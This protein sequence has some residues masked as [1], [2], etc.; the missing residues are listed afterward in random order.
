MS[1]RRSQAGPRDAASLG[2]GG[3]WRNAP[4]RW[5]HTAVGLHWLS[6]LMIFAL[7]VLGWVAVSWRLSP[8]KIE[9][10]VWHKSLGLTVLALTA[11]RVAWRLLDPRPAFP[12]SMRAWERRLA[13]VSHLALYL[14]LLLM[15][16]SGWIINSAANFPLKWFWVLPVPSLVGPSKGVQH[17]AEA[18]HL[19]LFW[20]LAVALSLH[21]AAALKHHFRD[22]DGVLT[23]MLPGLARRG[24][25]RS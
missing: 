2:S 5:G 12:A 10:F 22:R 19:A 14:I 6:A 17:G 8:T 3:R 16:L 25:A 7:M 15:P 13:G 21:V 4:T 18:V 9:L 1:P 20:L 11:L 23:G 24:G